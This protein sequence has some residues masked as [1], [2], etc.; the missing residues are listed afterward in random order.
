MIDP[1][2]GPDFRNSVTSR[3]VGVFSHIENGPC[4]QQFVAFTHSLTEFFLGPRQD[5]DD[6]SI[7]GRGVPMASH[8][9]TLAKPFPGNHFRRF[10]TQSTDMPN[11]FLFALQ[12]SPLPLI[13]FVEPFF[14]QGFEEFQFSP[15]FGLL[16]FEEA[17]ACSEDFAGVV[18]ASVLDLPRDELVEV[19][20]EVDISRGHGAISLRD[21]K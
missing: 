19:F 3:S 4:D 1:D 20:G 9:S 11:Q 17:Q 10:F 21:L 7:G 6:V 14:C 8:I 16:L 18:I 13:E 12:F 15:F 5:G 2:F